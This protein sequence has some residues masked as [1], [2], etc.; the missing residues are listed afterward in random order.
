MD[1]LNKIKGS[2]LAEVTVAMTIIAV[3][4]GIA[5]IT[6]ISIGTN[7]NFFIKS[8]A[9]LY[10]EQ[11]IAQTE[12]NIDTDDIAEYGNIVIEK[13]IETYQSHASLLQVSY[14]VYR[15]PHKYLFKKVVIVNKL[16]HEE[17]NNQ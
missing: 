4:S 1:V 13:H 9:Y 7:S 8:K 11:Y 12:S 2:T 10:L 14:S 3:I 17:L 6:F 16:E 5:M 15:K